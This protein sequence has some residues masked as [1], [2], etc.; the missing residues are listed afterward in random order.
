MRETVLL[1]DYAWPDDSVEREVVEAAGMQLVSGPAAPSPAK[2]IEALVAAHQPAGIMTCWA[3][4]SADAI[5]RSSPLKAVA[6]PGAGRD[7]IA[8]QAPP[9]RGGGFRTVPDNSSAKGP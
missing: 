4:V 7:N 8:V 6:R 9:P 1:T 5:A 2:D 3:E